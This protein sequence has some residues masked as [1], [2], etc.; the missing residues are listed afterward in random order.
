MIAR[1][2]VVLVSLAALHA[3]SAE[4][5]NWN[6]DKKC[7]YA[8]LEI[9]G[10]IEID[11]AKKLTN[12]LRDFNKFRSKENCSP[13]FG[14][15]LNSKGGN[16]SESLKMGRILREG[17]Y[18]VFIR[19]D[20]VCYSSC[21]FLL[22]AGVKRIVEG[23]VGIHR[24]YFS[25]IDDQLPRKEIQ[26]QRQIIIKDIKAYLSEMDVSDSL[27]EDM[28]SIPPEKIKLLS[29]SELNRYRLIGIDASAEEKE[30][31]TRAREFNLSSAQYRQ[32]HAIAIDKCLADVECY[33]AEMLKISVEEFKRRYEK[34]QM[35]CPK[36]TDS[37]ASK[38][39]ERYV[40]LG[41]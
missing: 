16:V 21:V 7:P 12:V 28:L 25:E 6:D 24:T 9:T 4:Y 23:K 3:E 35:M 29:Q 33:M 5:Y 37:K 13:T 8:N 31:A 11:E 2:I 26:R 40:V 15:M 36:G 39:Y 20:A 41:D 34:Y 32:R 14:V 10:S 27:A 38:C 18:T 1:I 17:N 30:I 19:S 22:A